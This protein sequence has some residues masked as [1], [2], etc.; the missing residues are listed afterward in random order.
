MMI[1]IVG[2]RKAHGQKALTVAT[3]W[4]FGLNAVDWLLL[5]TRQVCK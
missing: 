1:A 5:D 4:G 3:R 2:K